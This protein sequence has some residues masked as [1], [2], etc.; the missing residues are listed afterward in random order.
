[1]KPDTRIAYGLA[2]R[3][4]FE[5]SVRL[6]VQRFSRPSRSTT[7]APLRRRCPYSGARNIQRG[8]PAHKGEPDGDDRHPRGR[9]TVRIYPLLTKGRLTIPLRAAR[10]PTSLPP[11]QALTG[12]WILAVGPAARPTPPAATECPTFMNAGQSV[13]AGSQ[14][15]P[16]PC[17]SGTN[18]Q[19][20]DPMRS[21]FLQFMAAVAAAFIL[22]GAGQALA[23][24][25]QANPLFEQAEGL[26]AQVASSSL[27][28]EQKASFA[29]RFAALQAEQQNSLAARRP[30]RQRP[31]RRRLPERLQQ[32]RRCLAE[33][34]AKLQRRGECRDAAGQCAGNPGKPHRTD[35]RP[36]HR[37]ATA[38]P[39]ADEP[40]LHRADQLRFPRAGGGGR[41]P[42][43]RLGAGDPEAGRELHL[44][45]AVG[46]TRY[47]RHPCQHRVRWHGCPDA[48]FLDS[49]SAI[50]IV[51]RRREA[52]PG[53]A[54]SVSEIG[55]VWFLPAAFGRGQWARAECT[56]S[57][58][59]AA[60]SIGLPPPT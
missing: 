52:R 15:R 28:A 40:H 27:A 51:P 13:P 39:G 48:V 23:E 10:R 25:Q 26:A 42:G 46:L 20:G 44:R 3:E 2:E 22:A 58:K 9:R 37:P 38:M 16:V 56:Q 33:R 34:S 41:R 50:P 5:P 45:G 35:A 14:T 8:S 57:S 12:T 32:S 6:P 43:G 1:M 54:R 55:K 59:P 53:V 21:R 47:C 30:G 36:L 17:N 11:N 60:S 24:A 18:S 7:P 19:G 31:V 49:V 4:G 29:D